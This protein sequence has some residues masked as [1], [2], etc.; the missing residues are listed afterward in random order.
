MTTVLVWC[1][2]FGRY[3]VSLFLLTVGGAWPS[4]SLFFFIFLFSHDFV[5]SCVIF[6]YYHHCG[7]YVFPSFFVIFF[8]YLSDISFTLV[9]L[10]VPLF[11]CWLIECR[12]SLRSSFMIKIISTSK[13]YYQL[14]LSLILSNPIFL[15]FFLLS[16][17]HQLLCSLFLLQLWINFSFSFVL[18]LLSLTLSPLILIH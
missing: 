10:F 12:C 6:C 9:L 2:Y 7:R 15:L 5:A 11:G 3:S 18:I 16:G 4:H 17:V 8:L 13:Q 1:Q 14:I